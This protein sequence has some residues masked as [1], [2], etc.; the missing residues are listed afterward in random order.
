MQRVT[1]TLDDDL[2]RDVDALMHARGYQNR[3][4]AIRDLARSGL[5]RLK[6]EAT[7]EATYMGA[8]VYVYDHGARELSKRLTRHS[9]DHHDL[10]LSTLHVHINADSCLEVALLKGSGQALQQFSDEVTS[11]RSVRHG[12]LVLIPEV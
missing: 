10:T 1:L 4:E 7:P 8:L 12:Q 9:H 5:N 11:S 2:V 3:S 6:A